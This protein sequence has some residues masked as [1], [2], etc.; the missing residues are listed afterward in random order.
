MFRSGYV[1]TNGLYYIGYQNGVFSPTTRVDYANVWADEEQAAMVGRERLPSILRKQGYHTQY[2]SAHEENLKLIAE[3]EPNPEPPAPVAFKTAKLGETGV[4]EVDSMYKELANVASTMSKLAEMR[5]TCDTEI[6]RAEALQ[7]D[8]LHCIEFENG[9][10]GNGAKL[11]SKL[12]N[13]RVRRRAFKDMLELIDNSS[14][15]KSMEDWEASIKSTL[16]KREKR[17]YQPR[18]KEIFH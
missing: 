4:E 7:L 2:V 5:K 14:S 11:F 12:H 18:T 3:T 6:R 15:V 16:E 9:G 13:C 17:I 10:H 1:L 8:L